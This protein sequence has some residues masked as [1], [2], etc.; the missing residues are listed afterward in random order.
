MYSLCLV[1][2][3]GSGRYNDL[4]YLYLL[5]ESS[6]KR[7]VLS[8]SSLLAKEE[9]KLSRSGRKRT[10]MSGPFVH[11]TRMVLKVALVVLATN[12]ASALVAV[13]SFARFL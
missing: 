3:F 4:C 13:V 6:S 10:E 9:N 5:F 1:G 11:S 7:C 12:G 8:L 2:K